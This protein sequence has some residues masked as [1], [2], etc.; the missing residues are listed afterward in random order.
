MT[1]EILIEVFKNKACADGI[2]VSYQDG[3]F[4]FDIK[5]DPN[6]VFSFTNIVYITIEKK[7]LKH[8]IIYEKVSLEISKDEYDELLKIYEDTKL[9]Y[10]RT[11]EEEDKRIY[12]KNVQELLDIYK[13]CVSS[14][15]KVLVEKKNK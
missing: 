2:P 5:N 3:G 11:K 10:D 1:K 12:N 7:G 4:K 8:Y 14:T 13:T 9:E 15:R 6:D